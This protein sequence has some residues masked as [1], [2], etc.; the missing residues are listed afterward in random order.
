MLDMLSMKIFFQIMFPWQENDLGF[1]SDF[2]KLAL[3]KQHQNSPL[4]YTNTTPI[5]N[6]HDKGSVSGPQGKCTET[7]VIV[8]FIVKNCF[9]FARLL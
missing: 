8:D 3:Q 4:P 6:R 1:G 5:K 2:E 9:F 7:Y